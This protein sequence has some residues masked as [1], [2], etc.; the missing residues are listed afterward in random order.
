MKSLCI[1]FILI[2]T[3]Y[4]ADLDDIKKGKI[5][6]ESRNTP[7]EYRLTISSLNSYALNNIEKEQ[8]IK[9]IILSDTYFSQIPK[10]ELFL[11]TKTEIYKLALSYL[12]KNKNTYRVVDQKL[13]NSLEQRSSKD[14]NIF[15]KWMLNATISD[16]KKIISYKYY[17]TYL[18]Q[19]AQSKKLRT[20]E[21]VKIDK[22]INLLN[23]WIDLYLQNNDEQVN[24]RLRPLHFKIVNRMAFLTKIIHKTSSFEETPKLSTLSTLKFFTYSR[25]LTKTE[26]NLKKI[27]DVLDN[28]SLFPTPSDNYKK[29][30]TLPT[31]KNDWI[32]KD[33]MDK[34]KAQ[35]L[36]LF[37]DPDPD[38]KSPD[39]LPE[40]VNDWLLDN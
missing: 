21:L 40:P 38:Y 1:F 18:I 35:S 37:P 13:V 17:Q 24:M 6:L 23:P 27:E 32:P 33:D 15:S 28:I 31:P 5:F 11:L 22:K 39:N 30:E 25:E 20:I 29:P 19:K 16:I 34:L 9:D 2:H 26:S 36:D 7:L 10:S 3:L 14:L 4:A 8:L 12:S